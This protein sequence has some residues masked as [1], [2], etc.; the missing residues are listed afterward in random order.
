M[1]GL[2]G[3]NWS[4]VTFNYD[5]ILERTFV[6][7][8]SD[9]RNFVQRKSYAV[10]PIIVKVHG[11]INFRYALQER[12]LPTRTPRDIFKLMMA[13][14]QTP[15][16]GGVGTLDLNVKSLPDWHT[17]ATNPGV[18]IETYNF[19]VM[20]VPIHNTNITHSEF[21]QEN[22]SSAIAAVDKAHLVVA[23]GYNFGDKIFVEGL[24]NINL[25]EKEVIIVSGSDFSTNPNDCLAYTSL[26]TFWSGP[27][28]LF[29]GEKFTGFVDAIGPQRPA[30]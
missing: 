16:V 13:Y 1:E 8:G 25:G 30:Q 11:S 5:T 10:D 18:R 2:K 20:M 4:C 12:N 17:T 23:I 28:Y 3:A 27:L 9:G 7:A 19:P 22:V 26:S 21:F 15:S 24:K 29:K 14:P 6:A